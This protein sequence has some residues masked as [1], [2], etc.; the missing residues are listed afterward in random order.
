MTFSFGPALLRSSSEGK[1]GRRNGSMQ[2]GAKPGIANGSPIASL[3]Q[4]GAKQPHQ[5]GPNHQQRQCPYRPC[6]L[7]VAVRSATDLATPR[8]QIFSNVR[9][10]LKRQEQTPCYQG[11]QATQSDVEGLFLVQRPSAAGAAG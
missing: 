2:A 1:K 7:S 3:A 6:Q 5:Q 4:A 9:Q 11:K 10:N 8:P